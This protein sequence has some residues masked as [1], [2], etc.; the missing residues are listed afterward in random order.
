[1]GN[2]YFAIENPTFQPAMRIMQDITNAFPAAVTT[3]FDH[4]YITGTIVRLDIPVGFGMYQANTL[5]GTITV[6]GSTTFDID[7]DTTLFEPFLAIG[8]WPARA[9]SY[10]QIV[11]IGERN[12]I[13]TAAVMNTLPH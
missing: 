5:F 7:I 11:A 4:L 6:T 2:P 1:M 10:P 9:V 8:N 13:L 3:T 12:D